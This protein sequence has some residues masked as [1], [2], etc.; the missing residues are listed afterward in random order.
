M[1]YSF[2]EHNNF[3]LPNQRKRHGEEEEEGQEEK[4][5]G[6]SE[7]PFQQ[8][9]PL[10]KPSKP[11]VYYDKKDFYEE[12]IDELL[13]KKSQIQTLT[14]YQIINYFEEIFPNSTENAEQ[15]ADLIFMVFIFENKSAINKIYLCWPGP[16]SFTSR[17]ERKHPRVPQDEI[18]GLWSATW[19]RKS[20]LLHKG[21]QAKSQRYS[22][23]QV[24]GDANTLR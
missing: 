17:F 19:R 15:W 1:T 8:K 7:L 14:R 20:N 18:S 9:L 11:S 6:K 24:C 21:V 23:R 4:E 22:P 16:N 3:N 12:K 13:E 2:L 10:N 5:N